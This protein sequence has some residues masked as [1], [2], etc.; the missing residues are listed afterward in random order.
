[1]RATRPATIRLCAAI[2]TASMVLALA[3]LQGQQTPAPAPAGDKTTNTAAGAATS[4]GTP[5]PAASGDSGKA[6]TTASGQDKT[7]ADARQ[8]FVSALEKAAAKAETESKWSPSLVKFLTVSI[9]AFGAAVLAMMSYL[10]MHDR[11]AGVVLRLFTVPL[12]IV[13]AVFLVVTGFSNEQ[14]TPVVGL[15]GT[16]VGYIL[17]AHSAQSASPP[18]EPEK[19]DGSAGS[20]PVAKEKT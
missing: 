1:M 12:V 3:S 18:A 2:L 11:N 14:I 15:L 20:A 10:V 8:A 6:G 4:P 5:P 13:S 19:A 17:G 7:A 16:I 9:L